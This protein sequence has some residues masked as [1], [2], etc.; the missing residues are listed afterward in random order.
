LPPNRTTAITNGYISILI[1]Y[2]VNAITVTS[3]TVK[4]YVCTLSDP[5]SPLRVL[6]GTSSFDA[7]NTATLKSN[8]GLA[9]LPNFATNPGFKYEITSPSTNYITA[10]TLGTQQINTIN[11]FPYTTDKTYADS[12]TITIT[13]TLTFANSQQYS[14]SRDYTVNVFQYNIIGDDIVLFSAVQTDGQI[15]STSYS[16]DAP[17]DGGYN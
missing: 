13:Y 4:L 11:V 7:E 15:G 1:E 12:N 9:S 16:T 8:I 17:T 10:E 14:I 6:K 3:Q 5:D 2:K